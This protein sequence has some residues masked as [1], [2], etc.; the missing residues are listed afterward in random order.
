MGF[1]RLRR[2]GRDNVLKRIRLILGQKEQSIL[3][4]MTKGRSFHVELFWCKIILRADIIKERKF[5]GMCMSV[6]GGS[7]GEADSFV[8]PKH[9]VLCTPICNT[10]YLN[11]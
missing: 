3:N 2:E 5:S 8:R 11:V 6:D 10:F 4:K 9:S 1:R 7:V